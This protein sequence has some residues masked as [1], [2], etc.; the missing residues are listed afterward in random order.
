MKHFS[1][2]WQLW[3][4]I[5][6]FNFANVNYFFK[7]LTGA[8]IREKYS[9]IIITTC[10]TPD[11]RYLK[12]NNEKEEKSSPAFSPATRSKSE[13]NDVIYPGEFSPRSPGMHEAQGGGRRP[14]GVR[15]RQNDSPVI[16]IPHKYSRSAGKTRRNN[17]FFGMTIFFLERWP[18]V[19]GKARFSSWHRSLIKVSSLVKLGNLFLVVPILPVRPL[20]LIPMS[21]KRITLDELIW[22]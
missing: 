1:R 8:S 21:L 14:E 2:G 10:R 11:G 16:Y 4:W 5:R 15:E 3:R 18:L 9:G 22:K 7:F 20:Y 13:T 12:L 6:G 19:S 17:Q